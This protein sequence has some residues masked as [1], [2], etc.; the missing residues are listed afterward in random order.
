MK[1]VMC[2]CSQ[3][4]NP[5]FLQKGMIRKGTKKLPV[6]LTSTC[7]LL[8]YNKVQYD[9][10]NDENGTVSC[11]SDNGKATSNAKVDVLFKQKLACID[12][13]CANCMDITTYVKKH[14]LDLDLNQNVCYRQ[15]VVR[16]RKSV[17]EDS[18]VTG[19]VHVFL[20]A[21][22]LEALG[23]LTLLYKELALHIFQHNWQARRYELC[24]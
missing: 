18:T 17:N 12:G 4:E 24:K 9:Q 19:K 2:K 15:W 21:S 8:M 14:N 16:S 7:L 11:I 3:C 10:L 20:T 5:R 6:S 13:K 22:M 1:F 23:I